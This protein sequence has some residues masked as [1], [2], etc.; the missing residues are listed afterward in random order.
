MSNQFPDVRV[1]LIALAM[2]V[3]P[4]IAVAEASAESTAETDPL[5]DWAAL[6]I[7]VG[8]VATAFVAHEVGH[9][10]LNF[11]YGNVPT[12]ERTTYLGFIP[13]FSISPKISCDGD[14]CV[15]K[16]GV[17]FAGG[18]RGKYFIASAGINVQHLTDEIIL[19]H[20]PGLRS[21]RAPFRKGL[22]LFNTGLSI[23]Y[24]GSALSGTEVRQGD[25]RNMAK[26]AGIPSQVMGMMFLIPAVFD[27][28]RYFWPDSRVAPWISR[29]FKAGMVGVAVNL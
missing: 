19:S 20:E 25:L 2:L 24:A 18:R 17:V 29:T 7:G 14:R 12:F 28:F 4:G 23:A 26:A 10:L 16:D 11:S 9:L 21:R 8:G 1:L 27:I 3:V 22:L 5:V 6:G 15:D 13:F